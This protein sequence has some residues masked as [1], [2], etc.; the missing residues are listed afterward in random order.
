M[1][2]VYEHCMSLRRLKK[3]IMFK[4]YIKGV[5]Y[6]YQLNG[7]AIYDRLVYLT[8]MILDELWMHVSEWKTNHRQNIIATWKIYGKTN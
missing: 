8:H 2:C 6:I 4:T 1:T 7:C 3:W 5:V